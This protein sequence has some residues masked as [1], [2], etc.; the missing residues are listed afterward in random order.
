MSFVFLFFRKKQ[1]FAFLEVAFPRLIPLFHREVFVH[2][3]GCYTPLHGDNFP[4]EGFLFYLF[5]V[6]VQ[7]AQKTL[8]HISSHHQCC[9]FPLFQKLSVHPLSYSTHTSRS[10][11]HS[12]KKE[13]KRVC[14]GWS[15]TLT[16]FS[17]GALSLY[18][19][20]FLLPLF[21]RASFLPPKRPKTGQ[22]RQ[23]GK[24]GSAC[25][26]LPG[27]ASVGVQVES[28]DLQPSSRPRTSRWLAVRSSLRMK[29]YRNKPHAV[30]TVTTEKENEP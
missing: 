30:T 3:G 25:T 5:G 12:K 13:K 17:K 4:H 10:F 19:T 22:N 27:T 2:R 6:T 28:G 14:A 26:T 29:Q 8:H 9:C 24:M 16:P 7:H 11:V 15:F 1:I 20:N 21:C 18:H 23:V